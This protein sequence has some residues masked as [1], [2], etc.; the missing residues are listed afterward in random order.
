MPC[1]A[2]KARPT[3]RHASFTLVELIVVMTVIILVLALALPGL[4]GMN[5]DA[6]MTSAVQSISGMLQRAYYLSVAENTMTA[7]R[8]LPAEWDV[9]EDETPGK[10]GRQRVAVYRYVGTTQGD[11]DDVTAVKFDEYFERVADIPSVELPK[12]VWAAPLEALSEESIRI[13]NPQL[14]NPQT[15]FPF[16]AAFVLNGRIGP[17]AHDA[18]THGVYANDGWD[19]GQFSE[20]G[21]F[22]Q[23]DDFMMVFDPQ[24]GMLQGMPRPHK[25]KAY[26]PTREFE[27]TSAFNAETTRP[28]QRFNFTGVVLYNREAFTALGANVDGEARQ[29]LLQQMGRPYLAH[30]FSGGLL[31]GAQAP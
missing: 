22:F 14:G 10:V 26:S 3:G 28:Y 5:A 7:V 4:S 27:V 23:A 8:F 20:G 16:G 24:S 25:M 12:N 29:S 11:P 9:S 1:S 6:R 13:G 31:S 21:L 15:F 19:S 17:F 18:D 30:R 2:G